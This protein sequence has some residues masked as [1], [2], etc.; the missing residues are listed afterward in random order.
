MNWLKLRGKAEH[1]PFS[2]RQVFCF[3]NSAVNGVVCVGVLEVFLVP[4]LE[5]EDS[6]YMLFEKDRVPPIFHIAVRAGFLES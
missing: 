3:S 4:I 5:G 1:L 6:N 2:K